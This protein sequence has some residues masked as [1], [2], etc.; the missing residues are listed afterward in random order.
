MIRTVLSGLNAVRY[1]SASAN[2]VFH[3][4]SLIYGQ[5]G[6]TVPTGAMPY[7]VQR[8]PP[9]N[10]QV[11]C[12]NKGVNGQSW[13]GMRTTGSEVDALFVAGK[14]NVLVAWEG[15]NSQFGEGKTPAQAFADCQAYCADRLAA[16][17]GWLILH[18]TTIP[19][20]YQSWTD[21]DSAT[22]NAKL[23]AYNDLLR[24]GWRGTGAKGL[25]ETRQSGSAFL[26]ANYLRTTFAAANIAGQSIWSPNDQQ[27]GGGTGQNQFVHPSD[28]GY[29]ALAQM[30][31][32]ALRR[33]PKG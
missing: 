3:G 10:N 21:S 29:M 30:V 6:A 14:S 19:A 15:H 2:I 13:A 16:R 20:Y 25:V 7:Q 12:I 17:P 27:G 28:I 8:M 5:S 26:F 24:A 23:E 11:T 9:I 33:I 1:L 32:V 31:S 22:G 18:M 4:N